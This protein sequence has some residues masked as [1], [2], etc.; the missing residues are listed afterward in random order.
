MLHAITQLR[1]MHWV[2]GFWVALICVIFI[3]SKVHM[4]W[5][6]G[7]SWLIYSLWIKAFFVFQWCLWFS[8]GDGDFFS[9]LSSFTTKKLHQSQ[10]ISADHAGVVGQVG[11]NSGFWVFLN[12]GTAS[13][14][15]IHSTWTKLELQWRQTDK[16]KLNRITQKSCLPASLSCFPGGILGLQWQSYKWLFYSWDFIVV[17]SNTANETLPR[18]VLKLKT[19]FVYSFCPYKLSID[20]NY[21]RFRNVFIGAHSMWGM[22]VGREVYSV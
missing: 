22:C 21:Q 3:L 9:Y 2:E 17:F 12:W 15:E 16:Q 11:D 1:Q 14:W 8:L 10:L 4:K 20:K 19:C 18:F 13:S 5:F 7:S 6:C